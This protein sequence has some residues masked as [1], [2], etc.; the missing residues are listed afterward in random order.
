ML[1]LLLIPA[2][3][4]MFVAP[5]YAQNTDNPCPVGGVATVACPIINDGVVL[6]TIRSRLAGLIS[7]PGCGICISYYH[8]LVT[9]TGYVYNDKQK[10]VATVLAS[11]V[12]GVAKVDNQLRVSPTSEKDMRLAAEVRS[13]ISK[14]TY[15]GTY[16]VDV[17]DG[18]VRISGYARSELAYDMIPIIAGSVPGVVAVYNDLAISS[19]ESQIF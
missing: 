18:V 6:A 5:I 15:P 14:S 7:E 2:I 4:L 17:K 9:L 3:T 19:P 16:I 1:K 10:S 12:R 8:G 13:R 11:S